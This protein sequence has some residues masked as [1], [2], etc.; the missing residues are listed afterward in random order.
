LLPEPSVGSWSKNTLV[1][2][3]HS[4][5]GNVANRMCRARNTPSGDHGCH[6]PG[7]LPVAA[8]SGA[9]DSPRRLFTPFT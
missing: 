3:R 2:A 7:R 6:R 9:A 4:F 1:C 8:N 5:V